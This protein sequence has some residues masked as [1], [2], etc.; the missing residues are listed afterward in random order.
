ME[1]S[2]RIIPRRLTF[3]MASHAERRWLDGD[4][5]R[6]ALFDC[7][8][9]FLPE[10][11][12]FF[13]RTMGQ[14]ARQSNDEA[15]KGDIRRFCLQESNHLRAHEDYNQGLRRIGHDVDRM[16]RGV[17][18]LLRDRARDPLDALAKTCA[19]EQITASLA[20]AVLRHPEIM[21]GASARYRRLWMWHSLEELE[22]AGVALR[23]LKAATLGMS[24]FRR[25]W[26]RTWA[27]TFMTAWISHHL[28]LNVMRY[29]R[30][31]GQKVG[32]GFYVK[33]L[34][35]LFGRRGPARHAL[36]SFLRYYLPG[37]DPDRSHDMALVERARAVFERE[38]AAAEPRA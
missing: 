35:A 29:V 28:T 36:G 31:D 32:I 30:R 10:G 3:A 8:S 33:L 18:R 7:F 6:T 37:Y 11:E 13:L 15:L 4:L 24:G 34:A 5:F 14:L 21:A 2:S 1:V 38:I 26:L 9:L 25:Y 12:R 27:L 19:I 20:V 16:E 22:H 23:G 17:R